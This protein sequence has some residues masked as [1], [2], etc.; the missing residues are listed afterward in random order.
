MKMCLGTTTLLCAE[1][2][3]NLLNSLTKKKRKENRI[4]C[5]CKTASMRLYFPKTEVSVFKKDTIFNN[6]VW[7][8]SN[9]TLIWFQIG[10]YVY[11]LSIIDNIW[12]KVLHHLI[13]DSSLGFSNFLSNEEKNHEIVFWVFFHFCTENIFELAQNKLVNNNDTQLLMVFKQ[14]WNIQLKIVIIPTP[15]REHH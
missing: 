1:L 10:P 12:N 8:V 6:A 3:W 15:S 2:E 4:Q 11:N 14:K 9:W 5:Q 7:C 13:T